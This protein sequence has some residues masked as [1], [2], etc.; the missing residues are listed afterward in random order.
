MHLSIASAKELFRPA[1]ECGS[2]PKLLLVCPKTVETVAFSG[3]IP[4]LCN[5]DEVKLPPGKYEDIV[6]FLDSLPLIRLK[7]FYQ[8]VFYALAKEGCLSLFLSQ[9]PCEDKVFDEHHRACKEAGFCAPVLL[10]ENQAL[11]VTARACN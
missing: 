3:I 10:H 9:C 7:E 6:M 8:M 1:L 5:W 2:G 11:T 4:V